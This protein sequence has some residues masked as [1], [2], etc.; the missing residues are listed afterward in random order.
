MGVHDVEPAFV[1]RDV[2][3]RDDLCSLGVKVRRGD[4]EFDE[5]DE[6]V[7]GGFP[8]SVLPVVDVGR[9][10][11]RREHDV[12]ST[13]DHA[14]IRVA[15]GVG[16]LGRAVGQVFPDR[17]RVE[18]RHGVVVDRH[19][20]SPEN[21]NRLVVVERHSRLGEDPERHVVDRRHLLVGGDFIGGQPQEWLNYGSGDGLTG[22]LPPPPAPASHRNAR[23]CSEVTVG[24]SPCSIG[25]DILVGSRLPW[26]SQG[27]SECR[28]GYPWHCR[29]DASI[30]RFRSTMW[31]ERHPGQLD[32]APPRFV[33]V[34]G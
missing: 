11:D 23:L 27:C 34:L 3:R 28:N 17:F 15:G 30:S 10:C 9:T 5:R 29:I 32:R 6:V 33:R 26:P 16:E 1:E 2:I 25:V 31:N 21:P 20:V 14:P 7:V 8:S 12:V 22:G 13:D 18:T 4:R 19:A 24:S